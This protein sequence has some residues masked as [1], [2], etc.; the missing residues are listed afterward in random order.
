MTAPQR[1]ADAPDTAATLPPLN[2]PDR[3]EEV[4]GAHLRAL[5]SS[6]LHTLASTPVEQVEQQL[7]DADNDY[8]AVLEHKQPVA[9]ISHSDISRL[10]SHAYGRALF[11]TRPIVHFCAH[12]PP[13]ILRTDMPMR[14]VLA[15][16]ATRTAAQFQHDVVLT[17]DE[18]DFVGL[19]SAF[20]T[21]RVQEHFLSSAFD[22]LT[23]QH[24][25]IVKQM[26]RV[27]YELGLARAVQT[28]MLPRKHRFD[29][30]HIT[31]AGERLRLRIRTNYL[32]ATQLGGDFYHFFELGNGRIG[33]F[34]SDVMGHGVASALVV[35]LLRHHAEAARKYA[36][37][38]GAFLAR[39]NQ[40]LCATFAHDELMFATG[41]Y[42]HL[43]PKA[44]R[45]TL[46]SAGH[47]EPLLLQNCDVQPPA[48][49]GGTPLGMFADSEYPEVEFPFVAGSDLL[50]YTDGLFELRNPAGEILGETRLRELATN[51]L[52]SRPRGA[53]R[54]LMDEL[55]QYRDTRPYP[56]DIC[57]IRMQAEVGAPSAE[58]AFA[59]DLK[60]VALGRRFVIDCLNDR[61]ADAA[62]RHAFALA[63]TE[64]ATN[65]VKHGGS[66]SEEHFVLLI[67]SSS[68]MIRL[69]ISAPRASFHDRDDLLAHAADLDTI[70]I[71]SESGRGL[72]LVR[73]AFPDMG[74]T[75]R[76]QIDD[77]EHYRLQRARPGAGRELPGRLFTP[78]SEPG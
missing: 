25:A 5:V 75:P 32:S 26:D 41:L 69:E 24:R 14:E 62:T 8:I 13:V 16:L 53:V 38:P 47:P 1:A 9:L 37:A 71:F 57:V 45:C 46:A 31:P 3:P 40:Q 42:L 58:Q 56:D 70:D 19:I 2:L 48:W 43:D 39:M 65:L 4:D 30:E 11:S 76:G 27:Q 18:G 49:P 10:F 64:L 73:N 15:T 20:V 61:D 34:I 28:A 66:N 74:Y 59:L 23:E 17:D 63:V 67:D 33:L 68:T 12:T 29:I 78:V 50:L 54:K 52:R 55:D 21:N 77:H 7:A 60:G 44:G 72:G 35:S 51:A 36:D 6:T 22:Q